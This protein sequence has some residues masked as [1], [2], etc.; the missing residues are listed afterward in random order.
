MKEI[1]AN[2]G[3]VC[4]ACDAY[5]ARK[6]DDHELRQRTAINWSEMY[7][8]DLA[9]EEINCDGCTSS[10]GVLY[11]HCLTCEIRVCC[12]EKNLKHC[13]FCEEQSCGKLTAF[14]SRVPEAKAGYEKYL[15]AVNKVK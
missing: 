15:S 5:I 9:P 11:Q 1:I 12:Q 4:S 13:V 14:H 8:A 7:Q 10:K 2:C 3:L 6:T